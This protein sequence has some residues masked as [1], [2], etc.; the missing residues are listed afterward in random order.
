MA[1]ELTL[2]RI[3]I[4]TP[5]THATSIPGDRGNYYRND[6][7]I[8]TTR[9]VTQLTS[10]WDLVRA[11]VKNKDASA[12]D[13]SSKDILAK[14]TGSSGFKKILGS[15]MESEFVRLNADDFK[16]RGTINR[17]GK[18]FTDYGLSSESD[19]KI[20]LPSIEKD[21]DGTEYCALNGKTFTIDGKPYTPK[22]S[23]E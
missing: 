12:R 10:A 3:A 8:E 1:G 13:L 20:T 9:N 14:Y 18:E 16:A 21:S 11:E 5:E 2:N 23:Q 4:S 17:D 6:S 7:A 19:G 22:Q 15:E